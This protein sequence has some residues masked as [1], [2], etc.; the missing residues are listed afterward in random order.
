MKEGGFDPTSSGVLSDM[1]PTDG[2]DLKL[3]Q[4]VKNGV[5]Y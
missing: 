3:N 5:V 2:L 4:E 1:F